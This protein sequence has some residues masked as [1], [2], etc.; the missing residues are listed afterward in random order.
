MYARAQRLAHWFLLYRDS[1]LALK[2]TAPNRHF[3]WLPIGFNDRVF[4]DQD[5]ERD[6]YALWVGRRYEPLHSA[7]MHHCAKRGLHYEFF[8][9]P[10]RYM[11]L[12]ELSR[13]VARSRYFLAVPAD[14]EDPLRTGGMSTFAMRYLEGAA[15]GCRLLGAKPRSGEFDLMLPHDAIVECAPDGSNLEA[16]LEEADADPEFDRKAQTACAHVHALH[17]W[18]KRADWIYA[19]LQSGPEQDLFSVT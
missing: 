10:G 12:D 7:L 1:V 18:S 13:L 16:V 15:G 17:P 14:L 3:E 11:S 19:R 2:S 5:L 9:P 4:R 8:E 6:I